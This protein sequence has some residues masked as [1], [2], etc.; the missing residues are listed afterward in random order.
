M[1]EFTQKQFDAIKRNESGIKECPSGDY[2]AI[3]RFGAG[4]SFGKG[5]SFG[6]WCRFGKGCLA[7]SPYWS[8]V[9]EPP[10]ETTGK[11]YPTEAARGYWEEQLRI[12]LRG[13]YSEIEERVKSEI[14]DILKRKDLTKCERRIIASWL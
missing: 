11:I 14:P 4:C 5:C 13:C 12:S 3:S 1:K 10:F 9:Y 2:T 6:E 7:I 8:F